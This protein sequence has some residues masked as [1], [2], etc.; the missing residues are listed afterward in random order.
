M[1]CGDLLRCNKSRFDLLEQLICPHLSRAKCF[2]GDLPLGLFDEPEYADVT[3][4]LEP[5]DV[6]VMCSDGLDDCLIERS[7]GVPRRS[8]DQWVRRLAACPAQKIADDLIRVSEPLAASGSRPADDRT[9][10]VLKGI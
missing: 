5:G 2:N 7:A 3:L 1:E 10:V 6:L 8:V 9:V 4:V